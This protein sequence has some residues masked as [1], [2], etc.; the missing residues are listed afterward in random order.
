MIF[1]GD[2][3]VPFDMEPRI[4]KI[5]EVFANNAVIA[6]LEGTICSREQASLSE[7]RLFNTDAVFAFMRSCGVD[8]VTLANNHIM[9][10]PEA[11]SGTLEALRQNGLGYVGAGENAAEAA[12][13]LVMDDNGVR[14]V[15]AAF[16]WNVISC[17]YAGKNTPGVNPMEYDNVIRTVRRLREKYQ[18]DRLVT[19]LH[20]NYE[21]EKYPL[22][23][24]RRLARELIDMG[25]YAV[26]G[27]HP[28]CVQGIETY[29]G[30]TIAYS[31]G[32]FFI[33]QGV[34][35]NG[36]LKF[37]EYASEEMALEISDGGVNVHRFGYDAQEQTLSFCGSEQ[38]CDSARIKELTPFDG[39]S[40]KEYV[41]WF[42]KNR[43]KKKL[44]P[45]YTDYSKR[46]GNGI[47]DT[48]VLS[49]QRMINALFASGV[50]NRSGVKN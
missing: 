50:K 28:H 7:N 25:V 44:L 40:D 37:P 18:E 31:V 41:K 45:V 13:E 43:A 15:V 35:M 24:Q 39:M 23:A 4:D 32:N 6:N 22:P 20:W 10:V 5:P 19:I 3:A 42:R 11:F 33:P 17:V 1:L 34:Y 30:K 14:T 29:K 8:A 48:F 49:R 2:T 46:F 16:G 9:D 21:L 47:K 26:V 36:R 27:H 12:R 38:V